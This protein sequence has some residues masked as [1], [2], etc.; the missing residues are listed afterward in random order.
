MGWQLVKKPEALIENTLPTSATSVDWFPTAVDRRHL[1][2][3]SGMD[4]H[5]LS[6]FTYLLELCQF[7]SLTFAKESCNCS[8]VAAHIF[9]FRLFGDFHLVFNRLYFS[10]EF[11]L[12]EESPKFERL[13]PDNVFWINR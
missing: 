6:N 4:S 2:T 11:V 1:S 8:T 13:P 3:F 5:T 9:N 7:L 10:D 12:I